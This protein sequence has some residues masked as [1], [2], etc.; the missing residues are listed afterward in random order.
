[1]V[2]HEWS[3]AS[4]R[5]FFEKKKQKTFAPAGCGISGANAHGKQK[6]FG[7]FFQK[8]NCL[9]LTSFIPNRVGFDSWS[10]TA[11]LRESRGCQHSLA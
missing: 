4:K 3:K 9:L 10:A 2:D 1:L 5:F 8:N 11:T 6:F 7:Y